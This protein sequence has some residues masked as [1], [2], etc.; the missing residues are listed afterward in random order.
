MR[1]SVP[2]KFPGWAFV[3][4]KCFLSV[5][6]C[7]TFL[8]WIGFSSAFPMSVEMITSPPNSVHMLCFIDQF[9]C[10]VPFLHYK[11]VCQMVMIYSHFNILHYFL[12]RVFTLIFIKDVTLLF[13]FHT[14]IL[15][16][17]SC[18]IFSLELWSVLSSLTFEKISNKLLL[19]FH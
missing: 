18:W 1:I 3:I 2:Q 17:S 13:A 7:W 12:L 19:A 11:N 15:A 9:S 5:A 8:T 14:V 6:R 4:W 16:P 10:A